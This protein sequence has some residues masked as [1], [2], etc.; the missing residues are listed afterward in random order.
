LAPGGRGAF[1]VIVDGKKIYSK[2]TTGDFP[3]FDAILKTVG[4]MC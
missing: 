4:Q 3:D 2:F 1:E